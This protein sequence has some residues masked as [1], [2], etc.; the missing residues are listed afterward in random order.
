M[1]EWPIDLRGGAKGDQRARR[2]LAAALTRHLNWN[3]ART[4]E[5]MTGKVG[6]FWT[7]LSS[8][9]ITSLVEACRRDGLI[10]PLG[11]ELAADGVKVTETEWALTDRGRSLDTTKSL[12]VPDLLFGVVGTTTRAGSQIGIWVRRILTGAALLIPAAQFTGLINSLVVLGVAGVIAAVTIASGVRGE[13]ALRNTAERWP[14]LQQCRPSIHAWQLSEK[15]VWNSPVTWLA[16][17]LYTAAVGVWIE[18]TVGRFSAVEVVEGG[19]FVALFLAIALRYFL[20]FRTSAREYR[21]ERKEV[22]K[23]REAEGMKKR[24]GYGDRC[25]VALGSTDICPYLGQSAA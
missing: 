25:P 7:R 19:L 21:R 8:E 10:A 22:M 13:T 24:C 5:E 15:R 17:A 16:L 2:T 12:S 3:G 18:V 6:W 1:A 11:H 9:E 4:R 23:L 20:D 14:R